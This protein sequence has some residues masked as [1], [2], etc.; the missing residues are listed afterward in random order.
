MKRSLLVLGLAVMATA[1]GA[2]GPPTRPSATITAFLDC[3]NM[4]CDFDYFRTELAMVNWVRDRSVA[5]VHLLVTRQETGSGG[6]EHTGPTR[7]SFCTIPA[8]IAS[9]RTASSRSAS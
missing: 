7:T 2:Q 4:F 3:Q 6:S 5:D 9:G 1:G 8:A